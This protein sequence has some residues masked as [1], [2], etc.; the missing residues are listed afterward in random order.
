MKAPLVQAAL[1]ASTSDDPRPAERA[2]KNHKRLSNGED[3]IVNNKRASLWLQDGRA[4]E[5]EE[6]KA[7]VLKMMVNRK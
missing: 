4:H 6:P 5:L 2:M 3:V 1:A 7:Y